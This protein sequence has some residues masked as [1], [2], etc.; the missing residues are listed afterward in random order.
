ME[1]DATVDSGTLERMGSY[2][3][4]P[5]LEGACGGFERLSPFIF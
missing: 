2:I 4:F 5:P 3:I 1:V